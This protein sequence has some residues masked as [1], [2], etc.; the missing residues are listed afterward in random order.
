MGNSNASSRSSGR[1]NGGCRDK[2]GTARAASRGSRSR[3]GSGGGGDDAARVV[4][5]NADV[6]GKTAADDYYDVTVKEGEGGA[7]EKA[8]GSQPGSRSDAP[9]DAGS[10]AG[11]K[12]ETAGHRDG[13]SLQRG[14]DDAGVRPEV[15]FSGS[16]EAGSEANQMQWGSDDLI[17]ATSSIESSDADDFSDGGGVSAEGELEPR[18]LENDQDGNSQ[19]EDTDDISTALNSESELSGD[20]NQQ[21]SIAQR[22]AI[23]LAPILPGHSTK[24]DDQWKLSAY[25]TKMKL[26]AIFLMS[27]VIFMV[28]MQL[29]P[30]ILVQIIFLMYIVLSALPKFIFGSLMQGCKPH[31]RRAPS[32]SVDPEDPGKPPARTWHISAPKFSCHTC[33]YQEV[34]G[35]QYCSVCGSQVYEDHPILVTAC[36]TVH[37]EKNDE[38]EA[39][40]RSFE[41]SNLPFSA[42]YIQL[43]FIVDGRFDREGVFDEQQCEAAK[44][45]ISR[46]HGI[47]PDNI[48][49]DPSEGTIKFVPDL[50][51]WDP[52]IMP[53][54]MAVYRGQTVRGSPFVVLLK[55]TNAGKR[56]SHQVFFEYMDQ[57]VTKKT[58]DAIFFVDSDTMFAWEHSRNNFKKLYQFL[59]KRESMG[60]ACGEVASRT[61][62]P[63]SHSTNHSTQIEVL[64]WKKDPLAL[65][66]YFE[67]KSNQFLAKTA[68]NWFGM[69]TC[70]PGAFCVIRPQALEFVLNDYLSESLTVW[71]KN[72]LDLGEDRT[73]TT[74]LIQSGWDT[75][76]C[77]NAVARTDVPATLVNLIKQRRRW[78]NS[79]LV[80][81]TILVTHVRRPMAIPLLLSLAIELGSS[82]TLPTA[83]LMLFF[84]IGGEMGVYPPIV[85]GIVVLWVILLIVLSLTT[86]AE[87]LYWWFHGSAL[88]GACIIVIM[89][90]GIVLNFK[91]F[92]IRFWIELVVI[93]SWVAIIVSAALIHRQ[94]V[95]VLS[96]IAPVCWLLMT[97]VM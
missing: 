58:A 74:L 15:L 46:L 42:R 51:K 76:Y 29:A 59:T 12:D 73:L 39:G 10:T 32:R 1:R 6:S 61:T 48:V 93:V 13:D 38:L 9:Y 97:P 36:I 5:K 78:I 19:T 22:A 70:L 18:S 81:M 44:F 55:H 17:E 35:S 86:S 63:D 72:Q 94:W 77:A 89:I 20:P 64:S 71:Q 34:M 26:F 57:G 24:A 16:E 4:T 56:H 96:V 33:N 88:I 30:S 14:L 54:K 28:V 80:N 45:L 85:L 49:I 43:V 66:Q 92:L 25:K 40:V 41:L 67:Y 37:H 11:D 91:M 65:T 31:V 60:G 68:E 62:I 69:V 2:S 87:K 50:A 3:S 21:P 52:T 7:R 8:N 27:N 23:E 79:T 95:S 75:G 53:D 83:V 90:L 84:E 47:T 82:L